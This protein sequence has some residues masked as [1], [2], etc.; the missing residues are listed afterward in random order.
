M[1]RSSISVLFLSIILLLAAKPEAFAFQIAVSPMKFEIPLGHKPVRRSLKVINQGKT[2]LEV[3]VSIGHWDLDGKNKIRDIKPT[4]QSLD[5]W[6]VASPLK[7]KIP[8]GKARTLRFSIR[9]FTRPTIGEHRAMIYLDQEGPALK[10]ANGVTFKFRLGVPVYANVGRPV[11]LG[12]SHWDLDGKNKIRDIK[13]TSQSL[14][15]W[16]VASPLKFKIPSGKA[17]TLRFSIRPFTRPTIGE[18]RAMIYLDQEGPALKGANGVTFKFRLGVPVYANVGRPV[19]LGSIKGVVAKR[20]SIGFKIK[21]AGKF[22][23]R[24]KGNF[25]VWKAKSFPGSLTASRLL[26]QSGPAKSFIKPKSATNAGVLPTTPVLPGYNR[27]IPI[28]LKS[29]LR[30]GAYKIHLAGK[31]GDNPLHKT[32]SFTVY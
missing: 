12:S 14:D 15:Q 4:S 11:R 13:P 2:P 26:A 23:V 21:N 1:R 19:R 8:S 20:T 9:P 16:I 28:P 7:F 24:F 6:I 5:Q 27:T 18:H 25:G 31:L 29:R 32:Y 17:R 30:P 10:G 22:N 3:S